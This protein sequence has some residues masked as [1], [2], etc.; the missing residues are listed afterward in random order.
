ME[1]KEIRVRATCTNASKLDVSAMSDC[2]L[3]RVLIENIFGS[4]CCQLTTTITYYYLRLL[5][6]IIILYYVY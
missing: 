6:F 3:A 1:T 5:R 2:H 4:N